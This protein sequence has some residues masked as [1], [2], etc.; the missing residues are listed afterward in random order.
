ME[1]QKSWV[2]SIALLIFVLGLSYPFLGKTIESSP[3]WDNGDIFLYPFIPLLLFNG[4]ILG[5]LIKKRIASVV[6]VLVLGLTQS[7]LLGRSF[8]SWFLGFSFIGNLIIILV[9]VERTWSIRSVIGLVLI[10]PLI[11]CFSQFIW[12]PMSYFDRAK[13]RNA[14]IKARENVDTY[15]FKPEAKSDDH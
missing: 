5:P 9:L 14:E 11:T 8:N 4:C 10:P 2:P 12:Q 1:N 6:V 7:V 3:E 15:F 13:K